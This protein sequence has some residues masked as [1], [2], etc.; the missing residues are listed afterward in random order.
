MNGKLTFSEKTG[1][2]I[3]EAIELALAELGVSRDR[4]DHEVL[5]VPS[6]GLFG[7][8]GSKLAK[9]RV[10]IRPIDPV[11]E[12]TQF[13]K[14]VFKAMKVNVSMEKVTNDDHVVINLRGE[15]LGILIGKHGQTLDALQYL[16]NL[17]ANR[18]AD[19]RSRIVIDVED[20]RKRRAETLSRLA[21]RLADKVK[22]RGERVV[23]E[24]MSPQERKIIHMALQS[25]NRIMTYSEGDEPYRKVV[26]ALKR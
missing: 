15:D 8:I 1:K 11:D 25:D 2:T 18:D 3:E 23:L 10:A 19:E 14:S 24:P 5:E 26:I 9:V 6:K 13:L 22:R 21:M 20:Y 12:A 17:A 4:V 16:T 7:F